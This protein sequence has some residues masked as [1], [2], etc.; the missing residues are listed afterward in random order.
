VS[1]QRLFDLERGPR[2]RAML[3]AAASITSAWVVFM[4]VYYLLPIDSRF[5]GTVI[6]RLVLGV[7]LFVSLLWWQIRRVLRSDLPRVRAAEALGSAIP[8]F[9]TVFAT[10]YLSMAVASQSTFSQPLNHTKALYFTVTV[11]A[12]VGFGDI[13]PRTDPARLLV[14]AQM[15]LDFLVLGVVAR[16]L[17]QAANISLRR[18]SEQTPG[19]L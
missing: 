2:R 5:E 13:T 10:T 15:L 3:G 4:A 14:T 11:F 1:P 19:E 8:L 12:T 6:V 18:D 9:F 16:L 17:V 7:A